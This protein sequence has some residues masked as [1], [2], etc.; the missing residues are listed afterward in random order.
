MNKC[1]EILSLRRAGYVTRAHTIPHAMTQTIAEHS[2][3]ALSIILVLH[4]DPSMDLIK[5][6]LWHDTP[7]IHTGDVPAPVKRYNA[8][9]CHALNKAES[10][11]I[12]EH[13]TFNEA[14]FN[15]TDHEFL[16]LKAA[17]TL[18]LML[19]SD[20]QIAMGNTH[21]QMIRNKCSL[22]L[23]NDVTPKEI[24]DFINMYELDT[25]HMRYV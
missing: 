19:W 12:S 23:G 7:E 10:K 16:W 25:D 11:W 4:P 8:D 6:I 3:H 20:D 14:M 9:L 15:L 17:D 2:A 22:W 18:E 5:A 21:F 1:K 24:K 13:P